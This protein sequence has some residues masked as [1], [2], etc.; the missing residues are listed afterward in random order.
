MRGRDQEIIE[1]MHRDMPAM[2][3]VSA[4]RADPHHNATR[5]FDPPMVS[6]NINRKE[7]KRTVKRGGRKKKGK[8]PGAMYRVL[9][10][11]VYSSCAVSRTPAAR[12]V[13]VPS[14]V[15]VICHRANQYIQVHARESSEEKHFWISVS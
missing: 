1:R 15:K 4:G 7:S 12:C 2:V 14:C 11:L 6:S 5:V 3:E 13:A 9:H 10:T 8:G